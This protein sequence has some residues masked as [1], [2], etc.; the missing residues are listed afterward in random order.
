MKELTD[1]H[2][3]DVKTL[4]TQMNSVDIQTNHVADLTTL[5]K[6][7]SERIAELAQALPSRERGK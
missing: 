1:T 6:L 3:L 4:S 7:S 5:N 2:K